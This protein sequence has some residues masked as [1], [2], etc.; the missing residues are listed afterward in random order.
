MGVKDLARGEGFMLCRQGSFSFYRISSKLLC[1][2]LFLSLTFEPAACRS[3]VPAIVSY[4][5]LYIVWFKTSG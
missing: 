3:F 2:E 1:E 4:S 5:L